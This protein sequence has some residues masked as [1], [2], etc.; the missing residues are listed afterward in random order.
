MRSA[1]TARLTVKLIALGLLLAQ[2]RLVCARTGE[3]ADQVNARPI[4]ESVG[5]TIAFIGWTTP[6]P[7]GTILHYAIVHYGRDANHLDLTARSPTRINSAHSEMVF[8]VRM[9][10]LEPGTTY[11]Y[12]VSSEQANGIA[13][14]ATSIVHQF[15]TQSTDEI[16]AKK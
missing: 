9:Y 16:R 13:D 3:S 8:R 10:G 12:K 15:T 11:Y 4:I 5:T 7:G 6:N 2:P 14:P 1:T